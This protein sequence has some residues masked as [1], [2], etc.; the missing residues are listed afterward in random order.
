MARPSKY[1]QELRERAVRMVLESR[2]DYDSEYAAIKSIAGKLGITSPE[3]LRKW[4]RKA[5]IDAGRPAGQDE[6]GHR[7]DQGAEE[8][9]CRAAPGE[10]DPQERVGF[11]RGGARPP[12]TV[13]VDYVTAH[14]AEFGVEPICRVLTEHG[15]KIA[16][17]TYYDNVGRRPSGG[18][19]RDAQIV[20]LITR[21]A[22]PAEAVRPVR[23]AQD[24]AASARPGSRRGPLHDRAAL[25][26]AGLGRRDAAQEDPHHHPERR[27]RAAGR[28]GRP[29]LLRLARRTSCGSRTSPMSR[30]GPGRSTSRSSSTCSAGGSW[31]GARPPG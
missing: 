11:L 21:R 26:R 25:C 8:G 16:P 22:G 19:L 7:R 15:M 1:P 23:R 13:L 5:E 3:S 20:E 10:R 12:T 30:P 29:A 28:S 6:R 31:A 4:V 2:G 9:E 24:V 27:R 18:Q 17:S 14:K